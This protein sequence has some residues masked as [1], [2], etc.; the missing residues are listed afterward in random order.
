MII[1]TAEALRGQ[2]GP[3]AGKWW[4]MFLVV[5]GILAFIIAMC[6][7]FTL[8]VIMFFVVYSIVDFLTVK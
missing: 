2:A 3:R 1:R 6:S 7:N 4:N 5:I 8:G